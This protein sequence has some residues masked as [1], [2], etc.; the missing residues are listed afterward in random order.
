MVMSKLALITGA[1]RGIGKAIS[2]YFAQQGYSLILVSLNKDNLNATKLE[3]EAHY[4]SS[5]IETIS[6]DFNNPADVESAISSIIAEHSSIDVMVNSAGVLMAGHTNLTLKQ[7][8]ELINVNLLSTI[9]ACNLVIE[10][11]KQQGYGEI[12]NIGSTAGLEPVPKIAAYSATKAAIVSYSQSLYHELLPFNIKVCCLCP[13][14]VDTDMTN[15]GRIMNNLKIE[16]QDLTKAIDFIRNLSPSAS[17]S[18]LSIRCKTID[19]EK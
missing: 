12:Y 1:S 18:T 16:T 17:M 13:S 6:V 4:P 8:S 14:V 10:K 9:T 11:M 19:L 7:L 15:D 2:H 5:C 3:L